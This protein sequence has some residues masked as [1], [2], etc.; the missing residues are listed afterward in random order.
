MPL[1]GFLQKKSLHYTGIEQSHTTVVFLKKVFEKLGSSYAIKQLDL[2]EQEVAAE[3]D[4]FFACKVF[5]LLPRAVAQNLLHSVTAKKYFITFSTKTL[6]GKRMTVPR[7]GWFEKFLTT[8][9]FRYVLHSFP[10]ELVYEVTY[11]KS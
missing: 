5:D 4:Y 6:T 9:N 11:E 7:R 3:V 2:E 1:Y 8:N 10:N